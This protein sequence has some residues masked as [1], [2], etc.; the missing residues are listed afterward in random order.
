LKT[1]RPIIRFL[2]AVT[3]IHQGF[4]GRAWAQS[5]SVVTRVVWAPAPAAPGTA[6][7]D[8]ANPFTCAMG[9]FRISVN[10][11]SFGSDWHV[12]VRMSLPAGSP[13]FALEVMRDPAEFKIIGGDTWVT[14]GTTNTYFFRAGGFRNVNNIDIQYRLSNVTLADANLQQG[15][16]PITIVFTIVTGTVHPP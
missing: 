6:G 12:D 13:A 5:I 14:V 9:D 2:F 4:C 15:T 10:G 16:V 3:M 1:T 11:G 8:I 7:D